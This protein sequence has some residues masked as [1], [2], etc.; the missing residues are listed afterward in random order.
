MVYLNEASKAK[1]AK[2]PSLNLSRSEEAEQSN[3]KSIYSDKRES[4]RFLGGK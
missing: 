3:P 4:P 1:E 2:L